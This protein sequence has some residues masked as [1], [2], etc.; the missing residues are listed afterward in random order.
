MQGRT[1]SESV[2]ADGKI[3]IVTGAN[4]GIGKETAISLAKRGAKVILACR[5]IKRGTAAEED[6]RNASGSANVFFKKL[7]LFSLKSVREF[8]ETYV[9]IQSLTSSF[10][11]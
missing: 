10:Y 5:D 6:I 8:A 1:F 11:L 2:R 4:C 9:E 3:I 7:D